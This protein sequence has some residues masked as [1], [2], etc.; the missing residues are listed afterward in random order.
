MGGGSDIYATQHFVVSVEGSYAL[1]L[2]GLEGLDF[3]TLGI[4]LGYRF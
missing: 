2:G 4:G 3:W 1:P